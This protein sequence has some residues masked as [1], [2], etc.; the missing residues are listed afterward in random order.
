MGSLPGSGIRVM[1][2][3]RNEFGSLPLSSSFLENFKEN[4]YYVFSVCLIKFQGKS[5]W[6]GLFVLG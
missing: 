2:A 6:P 4:A 1:L 5:I 3:S